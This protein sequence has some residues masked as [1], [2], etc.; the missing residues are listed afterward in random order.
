M[1]ILAVAVP[2]ALIGLLIAGAAAMSASPTTTYRGPGVAQ[3]LGV[4][5]YLAKS[6]ASGAAD[7]EVT[8]RLR[9][10]RDGEAWLESTDASV[11]GN[12]QLPRLKLNPKSL[13]TIL[14]GLPKRTDGEFGFDGYAWFKGKP[15]VVNGEP[16]LS[17]ITQGA[18][19][20][21]GQEYDFE[22]LRG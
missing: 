2:I 21:D 5:E 15:A 12:A 13:D 18:V 4:V 7:H 9:V 20:H 17:H 19:F 1:L 11:A 22:L 6:A 14:A 8:G 3:R 16:A 10:R